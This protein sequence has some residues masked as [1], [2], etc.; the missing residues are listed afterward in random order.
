M[1]YISST[2]TFVLLKSKLCILMF[3]YSNIYKP[4]TPVDPRPIRVNRQGIRR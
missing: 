1:N 2:K 4:R 3:I